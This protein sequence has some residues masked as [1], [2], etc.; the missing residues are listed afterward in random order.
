MRAD[1][2][3]AIAIKRDRVTAV[4]AI[5]LAGDQVYELGFLGLLHKAPSLSSFAVGR[6]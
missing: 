1:A 2:A 4:P 6:A 5:P 3:V